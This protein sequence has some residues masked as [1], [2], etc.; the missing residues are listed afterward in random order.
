MHNNKRP[1]A[2]ACGP[3][4]QFTYYGLRTIVLVLPLLGSC[5]SS[6][7]YNMTDDWC[8]KH[9]NASAVRCPGNQPAEQRT[10]AIPTS[11]TCCTR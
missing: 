4:S 8:S 7:F 2:A 1:S 10:A 5:A 3:S 9:L 6:G 11:A